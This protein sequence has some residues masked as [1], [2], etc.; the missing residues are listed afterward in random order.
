MGKVVEMKS[1]KK[2][3]YIFALKAALTLI[4]VAACPVLFIWFEWY[5]SIT[6]LVALIVLYYLKEWRALAF[7]AAM[8]GMTFFLHTWFSWWIAAG[9]PL[10]ACIYFCFKA[11]VFMFRHNREVDAKQKFL[12]DQ[13]PKTFSERLK[14]SGEL[15][16]VMKKNPELF[17]E[18]KAEGSA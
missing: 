13:R 3:E 14:K 10:G 4:M 5:W 12:E 18:D 7:F 8:I 9:V 6:P 1:N 17:E 16:N 2:R 15:H 11:W